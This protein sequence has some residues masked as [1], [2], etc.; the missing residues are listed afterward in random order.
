MVNDLLGERRSGVG[1]EGLV[2]PFQNH[3]LFAIFDGHCG[4]HTARFVAGKVTSILLEEG[5]GGPW[6]GRLGGRGCVW[7]SA[8][9]RGAAGLRFL[10]ITDG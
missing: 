7:H 9:R 1:V 4:N 10:P 8:R 2:D 3:G 6:F 5:E